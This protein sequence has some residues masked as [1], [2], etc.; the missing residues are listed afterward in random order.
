MQVAGVKEDVSI[1]LWDMSGDHLY[2]SCW[3]AIMLNADGVL[4]VY[5]PAAPAQDQQISD[6]FEYFVRRNG[7]R[8]DQCI[9]FAHR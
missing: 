9:V 4:L 1:E 2:D 6:W 3:K 8:D 7:L 5:N